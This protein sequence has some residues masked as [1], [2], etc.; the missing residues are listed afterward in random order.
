M[1]KR[2]RNVPVK[3]TVLIPHS[4]ACPNSQH[5]DELLCLVAYAMHQPSPTTNTS[6]PTP[7]IGLKPLHK[8]PHTTWRSRL[9]QHKERLGPAASSAIELFESTH[10]TNTSASAKRRFKTHVQSTQNFEIEIVAWIPLA[11]R[12]DPQLA[13]R[14]GL[15]QQR[16][17][18]WR[19]VTCWTCGLNGDAFV[20]CGECGLARYCSPKCQQ[21]A[22]WHH[23]ETAYVR[24]YADKYGC[25]FEDQHQHRSSENHDHDHAHSFPR[26]FPVVVVMLACLVFY[27]LYEY[28][29]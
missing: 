26:I 13:Q 9:T 20:A 5:L 28:N 18:D 22:F 21:D 8:T 7:T 3:L 11:Q 23:R 12:L 16:D 27:A 6:T 2:K 29:I 14:A 25:C 10:G 17:A 24:E 19:S 4:V 15:V 1:F